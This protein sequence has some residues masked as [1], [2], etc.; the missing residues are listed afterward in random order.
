MTK[1]HPRPN[2]APPVSPP[3]RQLNTTK[4]LGLVV[5]CALFLAVEWSIDCAHA[6]NSDDNGFL[7]RFTYQD[8]T[9]DR[10]DGFFDYHPPD[11]N[12]IK[13]NEGDKLDQ[14]EGYNYKWNEG[15][16][17]TIT[18]NF[19][20]W[21]PDDGNQQCGRHHQSP[22]NLLREF[23]LVPGTHPNAAECIGTLLLLSLLTTDH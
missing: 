13:C 5:S 6:Q 7:D 3:K 1:S 2:Y 23:G 16:N 11:W 12:E 15:I 17:W 8:E 20:K 19:C 22:I 14:C 10:G 18:D 9:V 21:C 4:L